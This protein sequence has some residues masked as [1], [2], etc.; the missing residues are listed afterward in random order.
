M[1]LKTQQEQTEITEELFAASLRSLCYL[2]FKS[3]CIHY[4]KKRQG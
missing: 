1:N 4:L 2:L 3:E